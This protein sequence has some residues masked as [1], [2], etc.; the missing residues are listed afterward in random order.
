MSPM[1]DMGMYKFKYLET[2][3]VTPGLMLTQMKYM[4]QNN[5]VPLINEYV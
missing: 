2:V 3:K 1:V 5:S 4:N